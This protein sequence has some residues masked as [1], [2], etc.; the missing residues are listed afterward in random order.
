[1]FGGKSQSKLLSDAE[2]A[3][4]TVGHVLLAQ[5]HALAS[6]IIAALLA[7]GTTNVRTAGAV[8]RGHEL[9]DALVLVVA[10]RSPSEVAKALADPACGARVV[11]TGAAEVLATPTNAD[12]P[13]L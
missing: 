4:T 5:A 11:E 2:T 7:G 13:R 10:D 3:L 1:G 9:V 12:A 8:R 6:T